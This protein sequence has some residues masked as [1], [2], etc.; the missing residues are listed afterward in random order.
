MTVD[1]TSLDLC[2]CTHPRYEHR[3]Q[4]WPDPA[5]YGQCWHGGHGIDGTPDCTC[6]GF[7][8]AETHGDMPESFPCVPSDLMRNAVNAWQ[9]G[10]RLPWLNP[11]AEHVH[12]Y[13]RGHIECNRTPTCTADP[14]PASVVTAA[15]AAFSPEDIA[16]WPEM[17]AI[18][19]AMGIR[20]APGK[21]DDTLNDLAREYIDVLTQRVNAHTC[22]CHHRRD[23]HDTTPT[24][25]QDACT[26]G[27]YSLDG[28]TCPCTEYELADSAPD[29]IENL[30]D[31]VEE[32]DGEAPTSTF[33]TRDDRDLI[34][35]ARRWLTTHDEGAR[36]D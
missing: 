34:R 7:E 15:K 13:D 9:T 35:R 8:L 2:E 14:V 33:L 4:F 19:Q 24:G 27:R 28:N 26:Y 5:E 20:I 11:G 10:Q 21:A 3:W 32:I 1:T 31:L 16:S 17:Q 23:E 22:W 25:K 36:G 6:S 18:E 29:L 30:L 12:R